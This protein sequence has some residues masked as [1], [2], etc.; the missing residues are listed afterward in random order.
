MKRRIRSVYWDTN[1]LLDIFLERE[2]FFAPAAKLWL[3]IEKGTLPGFASALS[4]TTVDFIVKRQADRTAARAA[5]HAVRKVFRLASTSARA[6]ER[7]MDS[8]IRDFEDAVQY[9]TALEVKA[10]CL[11]TRNVGDF[12][13]PR[14]AKLSIYTPEELLVH[15]G[16]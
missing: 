1:V 3:L 4:L 10:G 2:P 13:S 5:I 12:P 11:I 14:T 15:L 9:F 7:A 8:R 6:V 16:S